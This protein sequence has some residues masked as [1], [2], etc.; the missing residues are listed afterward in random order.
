VIEAP[1]REKAWAEVEGAFQKLLLEWR[2]KRSA[3]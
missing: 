1:N 3:L 2:Q